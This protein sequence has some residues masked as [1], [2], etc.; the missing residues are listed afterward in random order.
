MPDYR[1]ALAAT[2]FAGI[3][4]TIGACSRTPVAE[5]DRPA[6]IRTDSM[7][8]PN[9]IYTTTASAPPSDSVVYL[10]I[11]DSVEWQ[12]FGPARVTGQPDGLLVTYHPFF[13]I[14]DTARVRRTSL[15]FFDSLRTKFVGGEPPFVV[16]RAVNLPAAKRVGPHQLH[17]WG[18]VI[19]KRA[20]GHWYGLHEVT[21]VRP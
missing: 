2:V 18:L 13:D 15:A 20:D 10:A 3:G 16:L 7:R 21:P 17:A 1:T 9:G 8:G 4:I 6:A 14:A 12:S 19:E 11:G 5:P